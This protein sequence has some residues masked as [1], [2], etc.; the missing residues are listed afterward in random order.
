METYSDKVE[1]TTRARKALEKMKQIEEKLNLHSQRINKSTIVFCK[2]K[3]RIKDYEN[4][5]K[6]SLL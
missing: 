3:V 6:K 5:I 1:D 2:N 4:Y